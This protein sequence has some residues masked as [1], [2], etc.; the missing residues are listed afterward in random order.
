MPVS[1]TDFQVTPLEF[2]RVQLCRTCRS[3][4]VWILT[5]TGKYMPLHVASAQVR[6]GKRY[7]ESHFAHCTSA[8]HHRRKTCR[9][10]R[11][12]GT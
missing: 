8:A 10:R 4:I 9:R 12:T 3:E 1:R 11:D 2:S 6:D 7:L 5:A